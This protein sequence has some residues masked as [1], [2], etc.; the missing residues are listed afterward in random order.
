MQRIEGPGDH[1]AGGALLEAAGEKHG[2][3]ST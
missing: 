1:Q 3:G 2:N